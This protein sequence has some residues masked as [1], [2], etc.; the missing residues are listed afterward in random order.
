MEV[1]LTTESSSH[2]G[3]LVMEHVLVELL[4]QLVQQ[5]RETWSPRSAPRRWLVLAANMPKCWFR[6]GTRRPND[7]ATLARQPKKDCMNATDVT[8]GQAEM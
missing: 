1:R 8:V 2:S 3:A 6:P 5:E 4:E 7:V